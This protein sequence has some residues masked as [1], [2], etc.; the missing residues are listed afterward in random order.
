LRLSRSPCTPRLDLAEDG[1]NY[2]RPTGSLR[3]YHD[4]LTLSR[5]H[6]LSLLLNMQFRGGSILRWQVGPI[7]FG[8]NIFLEQ[9]DGDR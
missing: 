5:W 8:G 1:R 4:E 9:D 7:I 2:S 3:F 6:G